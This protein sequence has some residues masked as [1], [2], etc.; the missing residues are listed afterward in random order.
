MAALSWRGLAAVSAAVILHLLSPSALRACQCA[1]KGPICAWFQDSDDPV[2]VGRV[3]ETQP[4][5]WWEFEARFVTLLESFGVPDIHEAI[6]EQLMDKASQAFAELY[7]DY[8]PG[9]SNPEP[10]RALAAVQS[11]DDFDRWEGTFGSQLKSRIVRLEVSEVFS[12]SVGQMFELRS[13]LHNCSTRFLL[14]EDYLVFARGQD[15]QWWTSSCTGTSLLD[16]GEAELEYLREYAASREAGRVFGTFYQHVFDPS[17]GGYSTDPIS[18]GEVIV[19]GGDRVWKTTT[20]SDGNFDVQN[21]PAGEYTVS[22]N[23]QHWPILERQS[24]RLRTFIPTPISRTVRAKGC[25]YVDLFAYQERGRIGG[26]LLDYQGQPL[27]NVSVDLISTG[28]EYRTPRAYSDAEGRFEFGRLEPGSYLVGVNIDGP[29]SA[30]KLDFRPYHPLYYPGVSERDRA[31]GVLVVRGDT[32]EIGDL[33]LGS[34]LQLRMIR[35]R[36]LVAGGGAIHG[37][38]YVELQQAG[39]RS[40]VDLTAA[41]AQTGSFVLQGLAG[42]EYSIVASLTGTASAQRLAG[43]TIVGVEE[44][45]AVVVVLTP[46]P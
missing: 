36:V 43:Q 42:F 27:E 12:G 13:G 33:R 24:F 37:A 46:V 38:A 6:P 21:L 8:W 28:G 26:R 7:S 41:D 45:G 2:F 22:G 19:R 35:G 31:L 11:A 16:F 9:S 29:P 34:P 14:G 5:P 23:Y 15:G 18:G 32:V 39:F 10:E 30:R 17:T 1:D 40:E 3:V 44:D 20:G 25:G 4:G